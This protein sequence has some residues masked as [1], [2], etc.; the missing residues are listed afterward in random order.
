M[1]GV[2]RVRDAI[3]RLPPVPPLVWVCGVGLIGLLAALRTGLFT[4]ASGKPQQRC[5]C[6]ACRKENHAHERHWLWS[7][8]RM[9]ISA[10]GAGAF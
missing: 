5:Q 9:P 6:E 8:C 1:A 4:N 2:M 3:G 7:Y 10:H